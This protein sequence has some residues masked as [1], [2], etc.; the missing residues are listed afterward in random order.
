MRTGYF[1]L[2][3]ALAFSGAAQATP[4]PVNAEGC[5]ESRKAGYHC[6][7]ERAKSGS[8]LPGGETHAQREKRMARECK[9][10]A[11]GGACLGYGSF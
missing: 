4:G 1:V 8:L 10:R 9:G 6:H 5:H 3:L 11:N 7:P 2:A